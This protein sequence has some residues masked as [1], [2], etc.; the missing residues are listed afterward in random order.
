MKAI[1]YLV[2]VIA[3][4]WPALGPAGILEGEEPDNHWYQSRLKWAMDSVCVVELF[5][6]QGNI[7]STGSGVIVDDRGIVLTAAHI[8]DFPYF[9]M[10]VTIRADKGKFYYGDV[11]DTFGLAMVPDHGD[12]TALLL[13]ADVPILH[14]L[15]VP[16]KPEVN[17]AERVYAVG[18]PNLRTWSIV[19]GIIS[20]FRYLPYKD[21]NC[22]IIQ[23][24]APIS[25]GS[26]GGAIISFR[27]DPIYPTNFP[28]NKT[29]CL[30]GMPIA[31]EPATPS[32]TYAIHPADIAA[33]LD[34]ARGYWSKQLKARYSF[35]Y[36]G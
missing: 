15:R 30:V 32:I 26:S 17:Y 12:I 19:D 21:S 35:I 9:S 4:T 2:L 22:R 27:P 31:F 18:H 14:Q 1:Y 8:V 16:E 13:A 28:E 24:S 10:R 3:L 6:R 11:I 5:D 23:L 29:A 34:H 33:V 7:I 20:G 36:D 25:F